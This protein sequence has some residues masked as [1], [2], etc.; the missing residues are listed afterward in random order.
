MKKVTQGQKAKKK[1]NAG[2]K[3]MDEKERKATFI[4]Y[5]PGLNIQKIRGESALKHK[6]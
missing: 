2:R 6:C 4:I 3:P 5:L 1:S